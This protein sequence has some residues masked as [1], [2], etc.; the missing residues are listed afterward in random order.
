MYTF[1]IFAVRL[2]VK[3]EQYWNSQLNL[4]VCTFAVPFEHVR[5]FLLLSTKLKSFMQEK[6]TY[7]NLGFFKLASIGSYINGTYLGS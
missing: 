1:K 5:F 2:S 4:N 6:P 7:K 3:T